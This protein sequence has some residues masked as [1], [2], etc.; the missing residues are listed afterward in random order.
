MKFLHLNFLPRSADAALLLLRIWFG[1]S[2][3]S[4]HGWGK[5][6]NFA[7]RSGR[8]ADPFGIGS[9][10]SLALVVFA[11]VFCA[12]L[13]VL[14]IF[15]RLAALITGFTM[16]MAFWAGHGARLTGPNHGELSFIFLGGFLALFLAGGGRFSVD[17]RIGAKR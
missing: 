15:T 8:F 6:V 17:A 9:T 11:E 2:L 10:A 7:D 16:F 4:L 3:L 14:G 5:L 12:A 1:L 13:L